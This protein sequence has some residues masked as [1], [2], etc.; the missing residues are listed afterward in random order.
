ML[1]QGVDSLHRVRVRAAKDELRHAGLGGHGLCGESGDREEAVTPP[2]HPRP[3][4][5]GASEK[6]PVPVRTGTHHR[7]SA[8]VRHTDTHT[9]LLAHQVMVL[10]TPPDSGANSA[11]FTPFFGYY[12]V[13][14][15]DLYLHF[16]LF[17]F[18]FVKSNF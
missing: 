9:D 6:A 18:S 15:D 16:C 3:V 2:L 8:M 17:Q 13:Y 14:D 11:S 4:L 12:F 5:T 1:G 10:P 7:L